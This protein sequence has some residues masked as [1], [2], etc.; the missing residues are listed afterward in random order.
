MSKPNTRSPSKYYTDALNEVMLS[1][2]PLLNQIQRSQVTG[3]RQYRQDMSRA[4]Q[5]YGALGNQLGNIGGA[6][7]TQTA[8]IPGELT[9]QLGGLSSLLGSSLGTVPDAERQAGVG[10]VGAIGSGTLEQL[11]SNR[12]RNAS[13]NTSAQRQGA[14]ENMTV[15][16]NWTAD[17]QNF[18]D[19]LTNRRIDVMESVPSQVQ[20]VE[21]NLRNDA[22]NRRMSLSQLALQRRGLSDQEAQ[23]Q[24]D[25]DAAAAQAAYTRKI[26]NAILHANDPAAITTP[27]DPNAPNTTN[28]PNGFGAPPAQGYDLYH[29]PALGTVPG[30]GQGLSGTASTA[31]SPSLSQSAQDFG[32]WFDWAT[33]REG[34]AWGDAWNKDVS[35][36]KSLSDWLAGLFR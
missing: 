29:T 30:T 9:S 22:F 13:F 4:K 10:M 12:S 26:I 8:G 2:Q 5:V 28:F 3:R 18:L 24:I 6:Y 31:A 19:D 32:N 21:R 17:F 35:A 20:S 36:Y 27:V 15:R 7:D 11:A 1:V 25:R 33:D 14:I 23:M 34:Q 16:R